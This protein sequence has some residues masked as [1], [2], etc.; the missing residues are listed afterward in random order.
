MVDLFLDSKPE[1]SISGKLRVGSSNYGWGDS[2]DQLGSELLRKIT[3]K[4]SAGRSRV[5]KQF[6]D[7]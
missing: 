7:K 2:S 1:F 6:K 5:K 4:W 3:K